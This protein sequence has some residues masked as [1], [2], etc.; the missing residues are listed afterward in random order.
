MVTT[1]NEINNAIKEVEI[2]QNE[3]DYAQGEFID[4]ATFKLTTAMAKLNVLLKIARQQT[5]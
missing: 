4:V 1:N 2:A 3:F 5:R